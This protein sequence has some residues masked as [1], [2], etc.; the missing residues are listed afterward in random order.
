MLSSASA[1]PL[2][3][4]TVM[5]IGGYNGHYL[6]TNEIFDPVRNRW[7]KIASDPV[8]REKAVTVLPSDGTVLVEGGLNPGGF[9]SVGE[10]YNPRT[11]KW[12]NLPPPKSQTP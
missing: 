1:V 2:P 12:A 7:K 8:P 5:V 11:D 6:Q 9:T 10:I 4:G 3:D